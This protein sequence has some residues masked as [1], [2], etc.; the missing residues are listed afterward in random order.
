M[1]YLINAVAEDYGW[2]YRFSPYSP[3]PYADTVVL[4]AAKLK[5]PKAAI[6]RYRQLKA[7]SGQRDAKGMLKAVWAS[8]PPDYLPNE[9]DLYGIAQLVAD[10]AHLRDAVELLRVEISEY[11]KFWQAYD[12][13]AD[14]YARL[15][16]TRLAIDAYQKDLALNPDNPDASAA[17]AKLKGVTR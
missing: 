17:L 9:W 13:L 12:L 1:R 8:N 4:A 6:R 7:V 14:L 2:S 11:P 3:W 5:G 16:D 15:G 10:P